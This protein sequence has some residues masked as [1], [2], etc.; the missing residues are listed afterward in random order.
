[1]TDPVGVGALDDPF[2]QFAETRM[3]GTQTK[4]LH[5]LVVSC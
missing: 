1:L 3:F 4:D 5:R 2:K